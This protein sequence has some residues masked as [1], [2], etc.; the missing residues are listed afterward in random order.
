YLSIRGNLA[1]T[2]SELTQPVD[3]VSNAPYA[4]HAKLTELASM[5]SS[6]ELAVVANVGP[7]VQPLTRDQYQQSQG[8]IPTNLFSHA[9]QQM[10]W[11]TSV[12]LGHSATG[13]AGRV[14]DYIE[15]QGLNPGS[16]PVFVSLAGN[17]L[18]GTG[19]QT[20]PVAI[21][22]GQSLQLKGFSNNCADCMERW[23]ALNSLLNSDSGLSLAQAANSTLRNSIA[24]AKALDAALSGGPPLKTTFPKT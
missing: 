15:K 1:L 24:D 3:S 2:T 9:D 7:L 16:F 20:S 23:D 14:A 5:F 19:A 18:L 8:A 6:R 12:P 13:W 22:P 17:S 10:Q 21:S 4:F 11:Q